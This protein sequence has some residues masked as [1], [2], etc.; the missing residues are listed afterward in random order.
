MEIAARYRPAGIGAEV[1]GDFYDAWP[2]ADGFALAIGD[3][4]GKGPA[5]AALTALTRHAMRVAARYESSPSRVLQVANEAILGHDNASEFCTAA[6]AFLRPSEDGYSMTVS[7]AGHAPPF[8]LRERTAEVE[9]AGICGTLLGVDVRAQF[10]DYTTHLGV[11]DLLAFWTDGVTERRNSGELFGEQRLADLLARLPG[12]SAETI[13]Q[14]IDEAVVAFAPGLPGRR[15]RHP[16]GTRATPGDD[17]RDRCGDRPGSRRAAGLTRVRIAILVTCLNDALFP[18]A[19]AATATVLRRLGHEVVFPE[20][21]TCCGQMHWNSGYRPEAVSLIR[22]TVSA[23]EPYDV[24][25]CPSGSCTAMIREQYARA[26]ADAGD[27]SLA[28]A[29][30]ALR[31]RVF[32]LSELL[33][34]RLGVEDVGAELR[35]RAVYHPT[36]HSLR[37]LRVGD[38]PYRLLR[39]VSGL[40]LVEL[41]RADECCGFGG[42][43]AVKNAETSAAMGEDKAAAVEA[44]GADVLV[45]GDRSC[46]MHIGGVLSRNAS[47]VRTLHLAEVLA[48]GGAT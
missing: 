2:V 9:E 31:S 10:H 15:R 1:G 38:R 27:D 16:R 17:R 35:A 30:A 34:D 29:V 44:S 48:S 8:V 4:A 33:I 40:E 19:G 3:V 12:A 7:C 26:A 28:A 37:G 25:V 23:L 45:A 41:S 36:C 24:I 21:Q 5:A 14:R 32:E 46:L 11:G 43:F 47:R 6:L 22:R 13:V 42:T 18:E 20:A 39:A